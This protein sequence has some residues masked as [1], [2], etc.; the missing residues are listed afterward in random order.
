MRPIPRALRRSSLAP[1]AGVALLASACSMFGHHGS[2]GTGG[3]VTSARATLRTASGGSAGVVTLQETPNG[4]LVTADLAGLPAGTHAMHFH[5]VGRC[6]PDFAAAGGHF[7]PAGRQHGLRNPQ[8]K[9]AGDLPNVNVPE[10]G[11][12]RVEL[13]LTDV[14][15]SGKNALLDADGSAVVIHALADDYVTDP[16]GGAGARIACGVIER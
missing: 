11:A 9:H 8:G 1:L 16:A 5:T 13:L 14:S 6:D 15:L 2:S 4:L 12:L 7:N 10:T 3:P